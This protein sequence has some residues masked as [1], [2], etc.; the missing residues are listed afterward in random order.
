MKPP[1]R[2]L[3]CLFIGQWHMHGATGHCG[4]LEICSCYCSPTFLLL[5]SSVALNSGQWFYDWSLRDGPAFFHNIFQSI[6]LLV[7]LHTGK[8]SGL[9]LLY[10]SIKPYRSSPK[11]SFFEFREM[12]TF[13]EKFNPFSTLTEAESLWDLQQWNSSYARSIFDCAWMRSIAQQEIFV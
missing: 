6:P 13:P 2:S 11:A 4:H 1:E 12:H 9:Y 5:S 10:F 3:F 7:M 8:R